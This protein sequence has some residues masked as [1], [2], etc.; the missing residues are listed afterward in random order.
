MA[1][2]PSS[3]RALWPLLTRQQVRQGEVLFEMRAP[4]PHLYFIESGLVAL[5]KPMRDGR[6]AEI[7]AIG[8]EGIITPTG[9][10]GAE[11]T[12]MESVVEIPGSVLRIDRDAFRERLARD[13]AF[14]DLI[15]QYAGLVMDQLTQTAAC[16][17]LHSIEQRCSRWF[18]VAQDSAPSEP[19]R[20][21]HEFLATVLGV[22]RASVQVAA[23]A[24]ARA[25]SISYGRGSV[26]V[27]DR[28][29]LEAS[30]CECYATI[31]E[32]FD[33]LFSRVS[34]AS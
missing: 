28:A 32:Q 23:A 4:I 25:G 33:G 11:R 5:S 12:A 19:F 3:R 31:A 18:L 9:V 29:R 34:R 15:A 16:N 22:R 30:A 27:T 17:I 14:S 20:L 2:P 26:T 7:G 13:G 10:F 21:T 1:L 8:R 6:S 24:L